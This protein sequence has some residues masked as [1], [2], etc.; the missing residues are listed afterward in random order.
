MV[1]P[2]ASSL[3]AMPGEGGEM[4]S[5]TVVPIVWKTVVLRSMQF[6]RS[7]AV[8]IISNG[9]ISAHNVFLELAPCH[10]HIYTTD[11][12][13]W[14]DV[15]GTH[16]N[17]GCERVQQLGARIVSWCSLQMDP[18]PEVQETGPDGFI[19][20]GQSG[21]RI[22]PHPGEHTM[23]HGV[24]LLVTLE[25]KGSKRR[26]P[27]GRANELLHLITS[28]PQSRV[29]L[30][31]AG[32]SLA[33]SAREVSASIDHDGFISA[34][35]GACY[36]ANCR[37]PVPGP[38]DNVTTWRLLAQLGWRTRQMVYMPQQHEVLEVVREWSISLLA[39]LCTG[40]YEWCMRQDEPS[41]HALLATQPPGKRGGPLLRCR[42]ADKKNIR[43]ARRA[44]TE[45]GAK[46]APGPDSVLKFVCA[47]HLSKVRKRFAG[48]PVLE[49][50]FD[51]SQVG[52]RNHDVFATYT[53]TGVGGTGTH[54]EGVGTYLP[55]VRVPELAWRARDA[56]EGITG[57]DSEWWEIRGWK[58]R[59]GVRV[60]QAARS[61]QHVLVNMLST[62][63][64]DFRAPKGL[65]RMSV[66][67][68]CIWEEEEARL[69]RGVSPNM[70][71]ELTGENKSNQTPGQEGEALDSPRQNHTP[72]HT[73][74]NRHRHTEI[75]T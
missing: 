51:G 2:C 15:Q 10:D 64:T 16:R 65:S 9:D 71:P 40:F 43:G 1:P 49:L 52:I 54:C 38:A 18:R 45:D 42:L 31:C 61:V 14:L 72:I 53:P 26:D 66:G 74:A 32:G 5:E 35:A 56:D 67:D 69:Y 48:V 33:I 4:S 24:F 7:V 17:W 13:R 36:D 29:D 23:A 57:E 20:D 46:G 30:P 58:T 22:L 11:C 47:T 75:H 27:V 3:V 6:H 59:A 37:S 60:H 39:W 19:R 12:Y 62:T 63:I 28:L 50:C 55:P 44:W 8:A 41:T 25:A 34:M 21:H 70:V 73:E 68:T